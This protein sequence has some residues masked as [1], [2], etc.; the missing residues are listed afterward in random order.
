MDFDSF[1]TFLFILLFFI[2]PSILKQIQARK[3]KK[4]VLKP[5]KKKSSFF[6]RISDQ[7]QQFV[8][9][10]EA[11]AQ[12]QKKANKDQETMWEALSEDEAFHSEIETLEKNTDEDG[13]TRDIPRKRVEQDVS[14]QKPK[15]QSLSIED[16]TSGIEK[17]RPL[18][19]PYQ[20][21]SHPLQNAVIWSEILSRPLALR[22]EDNSGI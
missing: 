5:K 9:D 18:S 13:S 2:L 8:K 16:S 10:L 11:Q 21:K 20:L 14:F 1:I 7:I 3:K 19:D 12:Q 4:E 22:E 17:P 6:N 15:K